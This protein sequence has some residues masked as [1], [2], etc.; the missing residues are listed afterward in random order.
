MPKWKRFIGKRYVG[1]NSRSSL[2]R[3]FE[4]VEKEERNIEPI[5]EDENKNEDIKTKEDLEDEEN[6]EDL[7]AKLV[8]S[9]E[10]ISSLKRENE[11]L[12]MVTMTLTRQERKLTFSC[13]K[14]K[15]E[16]RSSPS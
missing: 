6:E 1:Q 12:K 13:F 11:E 4:D 7:K 8:A 10:E 3:S 2:K 5:K 14:Y 9:L 15:K 16:M